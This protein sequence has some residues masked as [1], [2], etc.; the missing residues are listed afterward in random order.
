MPNINDF[1]EQPQTP[2]P[3]RSMSDIRALIRGIDRAELSKLNTDLARMLVEE[4]ITCHEPSIKMLKHARALSTRIDNVLI[5][6]PTGTG[7]ELVARI[8]HQGR[9]GR[10]VAINCSGLPDGLFESLLFGHAKG[11]Y[12]GAIARNAGLLRAAENGTAFLDEIGDLPMHQQTKLLRVI[13]SRKVRGIGEDQEFPINCRFCFAT[14][15]DLRG[16]I[17]TNQFREDLYYRISSFVLRT[18][19]LAERPG[20]AEMI[21]RAIS[22]RNNWTDAEDPSVR[23]I[24]AEAIAGN[25]RSL[26]NYLTRMEVL[27]L[28]SEQALVDI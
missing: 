2:P 15:K 7:K 16:M 27:G 25:C 9:R 5:M 12:T 10:L 14:N 19:A 28:T 6:G 21:A 23:L 17:A 22:Q 13:E 1:S 8:L 11:S 3:E 24:P 20:D 18:Y 26:I 4:Y